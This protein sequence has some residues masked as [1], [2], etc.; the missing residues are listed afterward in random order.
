MRGNRRKFKW[1][2]QKIVWQ[3]FIVYLLIS[4]DLQNRQTKESSSQG[5]WALMILIMLLMQLTDYLDNYANN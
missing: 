3:V 2:L 1:P 5:S 4:S